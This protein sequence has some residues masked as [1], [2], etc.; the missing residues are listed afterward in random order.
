MVARRSTSFVP[1]VSTAGAEG[2]HGEAMGV[3]MGVKV[4][5]AMVWSVEAIGASRAVDRSVLTWGHGARYGFTYGTPEAGS[6]MAYVQCVAPRGK[7]PCAFV[8]TDK[9]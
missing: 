7:L 6:R 4:G 9:T 3:A 2:C 8:G 1:G 5:E